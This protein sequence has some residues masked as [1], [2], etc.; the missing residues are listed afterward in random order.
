MKIQLSLAL[1][2]L[3]VETSQ[4]FLPATKYVASHG[5]IKSSSKSVTAIQQEISESVIQSEKYEDTSLTT[6]TT[7]IQEDGVRTL[8]QQIISAL[9]YRELIHELRIR[10]Q[11]TTGTTSQLR[12]RLRQVALP[13]QMEECVVNEDDIDD[14]CVTNVSVLRKA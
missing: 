2:A 10:D 7:T 9:P 11:I 6:T 5:V 3:G 1:L 12:S 4:A 14:D 8:T 13:D